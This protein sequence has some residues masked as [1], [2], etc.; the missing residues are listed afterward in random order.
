MTYETFIKYGTKIAIFLSACAIGLVIFAFNAEA[1]PYI[2]A[3][4]GASLWR[5][6]S[7]N[8]EIEASCD[9]EPMGGVNAGYQFK[10]VAL[11]GEVSVRAAT[12]HNV[13]DKDIDGGRTIGRGDEDGYVLTGMVNAKPGVKIGKWR[14]Y[15]LIGVGLGRA[16]LARESDH[17]WAAQ[18]G[19]GVDFSLTEALSVDL[20]YRYLRLGDTEHQGLSASYDSHGVI[21]GVRYEF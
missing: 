8:D 10:Y 7:N 19:L 17:S 20:G 2:G 21:L 9:A 1:D 12:T 15:G 16:R 14:P 6:C 13:K 4:G 11:E 5:D 3:F 18:A